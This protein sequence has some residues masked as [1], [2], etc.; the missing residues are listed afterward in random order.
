MIPHALNGLT[1]VER[2]YCYTESENTS[3]IA[4]KIKEKP[5][6]G[7]Y[8]LQSDKL[9][10]GYEILKDTRGGFWVSFVARLHDGCS[11]ALYKQAAAL[12]IQDV[13]TRC[14]DNKS[15]RIGWPNEIWCN[16]KIVGFIN[17]EQF[18]GE[19]DVVI[20]G[21]ELFIN[22]FQDQISSGFEEKYTTMLAE[23][24]S[25]QTIGTT[26]RVIVEEFN[27]NL[28]EKGSSLNRRYNELLYG[29][30]IN[31]TINGTNGTLDHV[32]ENGAACLVID[33]KSTGIVS[34]ICTYNNRI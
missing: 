16:E 33:G 1:Y 13:L 28:H 6:K 23:T 30:G 4:K 27:K 25:C 8:V 12:A 14:I 18:P 9:T 24:G 5:Q 2:L 11:L 34:G 21:F 22:V 3:H 17:G 32:D 20:I 15:I 19:E 31:V 29:R 7:F 10:T 26:L